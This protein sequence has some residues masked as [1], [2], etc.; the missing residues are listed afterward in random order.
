MLVGLQG[1]VR[2]VG[3]LM[4][5]RPVARLFFFDNLAASLGLLSSLG[6]DFGGI[7]PMYRI[8]S[9]F[10][11]GAPLLF[12]SV[13]GATIGAVPHKYCN[14]CATTVQVSRIGKWVAR[15]IGQIRAIENGL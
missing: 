8:N 3:K 12:S 15:V 2:V 13:T 7:L 14:I 11:I 1:L 10:A 6:G 5:T 9:P 4:T